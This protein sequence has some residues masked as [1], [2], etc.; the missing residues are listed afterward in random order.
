MQKTLWI[1]TLCVIFHFCSYAQF[2]HELVGGLNLSTIKSQT[3]REP[4]PSTGFNVGWCGQLHL[5]TRVALVS[6]VLYTE[7][8]FIKNHVSRRFSYATLPVMV[9]YFV[10]KRLSVDVG[11]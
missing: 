10:L 9:R 5:K 7:K 1:G 6:G 3:T 2:D 4:E 8:G 11:G